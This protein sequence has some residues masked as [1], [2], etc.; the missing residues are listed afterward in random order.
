MI[1]RNNLFKAE[2]IEQLTLVPIELTHHGIAPS[3]IAIPRRN[4]CSQAPSTTF[5]TKSAQSGVSLRRRISVA[6]GAKRTCRARRELVDP[7]RLTPTGHGRIENPAAQR[8]PADGAMLWRFGGSRFR[9]F[10]VCPKDP[11]AC[12]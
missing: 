1:G 10:Q 9:T 6:I 12:L 11:S 3:R 4:H 7:A 2:R 5:A 8:S